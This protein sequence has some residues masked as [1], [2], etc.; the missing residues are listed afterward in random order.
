MKGGSIVIDDYLRAK[1]V[2]GRYVGKAGS[3]HTI[4]AY[5]IALTAAERLIGKPLLS[6]DEIDGDELVMRFE[7]ENF[8]PSYRANILA[9]LRGYFTWAIGTKRYEGTHP[10][11][12]LATPRV[13]RIIPTILSEH[14]VKVFF[15]VLRGKYKL[16]FELM[17]Y[18]G[19]RIGEVCQLRREDVRP[20]GIVVRGKGNKQRYVYLP[21]SLRERLEGY[22]SL[23]RSSD[24]VFYG[25][26][27]NAKKDSP[28]TLAQARREFNAARDK[29]G[30]KIHPH[31]L[32][33]T[34]ATHFHSKVG[35]LA[36]TQRFLGHA[37]PETTTIYAQIADS[38]LKDASASVFG[39]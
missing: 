38:K 3:A 19:L 17:Y 36:I 28:L 7:E 2:G 34:S 1:K 21:Q 9:A 20:D 33:H 12:S 23:H 32:R 30:F 10:L 14:E 18:G 27:A 6:F 24:F 15:S 4:A 29:C 13:E 8:A 11:Q 39:V 37:R 35:D 31:N 5:R 16:F 22:I 25:E 26:T